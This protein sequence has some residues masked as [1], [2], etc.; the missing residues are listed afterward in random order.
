MLIIKVLAG[1][2]F[3]VDIA[4]FKLIKLYPPFR[5]YI[6]PYSDIRDGGICSNAFLP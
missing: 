2:S 1:I 6:G 3:A 5:K 4:S